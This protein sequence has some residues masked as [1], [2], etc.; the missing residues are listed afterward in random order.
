MAKQDCCQNLREVMG[1]LIAALLVLFGVLVSGCAARGPKGPKEAAGEYVFLAPA[2]NVE[3]LI[4]RA[5]WT[6]RHELFKDI[7]AYREG[8]DPMSTNTGTWAYDRAR[9]TVM[10]WVDFLD[11]DLKR[12]DPPRKT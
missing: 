9:F 5:D 2:G 3:C 7:E 10:G 4:L 11:L 8:I 1:P 6:Y 12:L